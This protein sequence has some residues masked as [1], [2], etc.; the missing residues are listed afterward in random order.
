M[1][2]RKCPA[3]KWVTPTYTG[4]DSSINETTSA[5]GSARRRSRDQQ[6]GFA[7]NS[8]QMK[9][10]L[11]QNTRIDHDLY[12]SRH[13]NGLT[14]QRDSPSLHT[15]SSVAHTHTRTPTIGAIFLN[16]PG[17]A[18]YQT[19]EKSSAGSEQKTAT[20]CAGRLPTFAGSLLEMAT[21][22]H[23]KDAVLNPKFTN[24]RGGWFLFAGESEASFIDSNTIISAAHVG[25]VLV[26]LQFMNALHAEIPH[27]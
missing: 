18:C 2:T 9:F 22:P 5:S 13:P 17:L 1:F 24:A 3:Y 21:C 12:R 14:V 10:L 20:T 27:A 26:R 7:A 23:G 16:P 25:S 8:A 6:E 4:W 19:H 15:S 11:L